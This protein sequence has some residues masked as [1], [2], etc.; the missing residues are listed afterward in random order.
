[1]MD[2]QDLRAPCKAPYIDSLCKVPVFIAYGAL[3]GAV[4]SCKIY[5]FYC[6]EG[7]AGGLG[8]TDLPDQWSKVI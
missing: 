4:R 1:M 7:E 6:C 2:L 3:Q 5:Y 8:S